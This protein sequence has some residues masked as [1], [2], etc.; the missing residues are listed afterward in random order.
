[1][2]NRQIRTPINPRISQPPDAQPATG[3]ISYQGDGKG[4]DAQSPAA[5]RQQRTT[6]GPI[7]G[8]PAVN[9]RC[10]AVHRLEGIERRRR[11][12]MLT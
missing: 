2:Q 4:C 10:R 8:I 11:R 1:M 5:C 9:V 12:R 3:L 7:V 6:R